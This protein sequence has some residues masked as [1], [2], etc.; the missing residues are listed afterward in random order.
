MPQT[1]HQSHRDDDQ[2]CDPVLLSIVMPCLNEAETVGTCVR[3]ARAALDRLNICGE[4]IVADNGS[5]DGSPQIAEQAGARVV[6]VSARGYGSALIGGSEAARGQY[7]IMGDADDSY[8][9]GNIEPFVTALRAGADLVMGNRFKG[10]IKP[11]AMRPLHQYFGNPLLSGIGRLFFNSSCGDFHCGMRGYTKAAFERMDL[12]TTGM[13]FA[14]EMVVKATLL[15]LKITEVPI[16]LYPDGRSR[17]PHLR[18]FRDGW[19]HLRFLLLYSPRWL[20]L[21]P[22]L[23]AIALGLMIWALL[24]PGPLRIG[25]VRFDVHTLLYG[26]TLIFLGFQ[27]VWFAVFTKVFAANEGLL[28]RD[29]RLT[30]L[31]RSLSLE[32]GLIIGVALLFLG[33]AGTV[34]ALAL[35]SRQDF[36]D[37]EYG[38]MLRLVIPSITGITLGAQIILSSFF[39]SVL[40]LKRRQVAALAR[41]ETP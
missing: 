1:T 24:L 4:V 35:W 2:P 14:S 39:L 13:E 30:L 40:R 20:F 8:D 28:P 9:F 23:G 18:S 12:R 29:E 27:S 5:T 34:Y 3:K 33:V 19:R 6:H 38:T 17:P 22:G 36:G 31:S 11:G 32:A 26:M 37:L 16:I 21:Y 41:S 25:T 10:G 7:I 15:K